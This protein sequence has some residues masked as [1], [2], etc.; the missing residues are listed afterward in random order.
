[1]EGLH[2]DFDDDDTTAESNR[3]GDFSRMSSTQPETSVTD[4]LFEWD[5][6]WQ[7]ASQPLHT[8]RNHDFWANI[9]EDPAMSQF[10]PQPQLSLSLVS[11]LFY[12]LFPYPPNYHSVGLPFAL[13]CL[14]RS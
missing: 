10:A 5:R 3:L 11:N 8:S 9:A 12:P 1:M 2:V 14:I 6:P 4:V 7:S 13:S